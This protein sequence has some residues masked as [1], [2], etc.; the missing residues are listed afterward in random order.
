MLSL[1]K[2]IIGGFAF[3][4]NLHAC[5]EIATEIP[6]DIGFASPLAKRKQKKKK[7]S[8][9]YFFKSKC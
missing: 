3:G 8:I 6:E 5:F 7:N 1:S 2:V 4:S 9:F